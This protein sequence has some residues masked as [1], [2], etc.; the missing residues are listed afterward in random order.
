VRP[1]SR[2]CR[3]QT[4]TQTAAA[5]RQELRLRFLRQPS[6][7]LEDAESFRRGPEVEPR[8]GRSETR[9]TL[10]ARS[11][12]LAFR[13]LLIDAWPMGPIMNYCGAIPF[14][15]RATATSPFNKRATTISAPLIQ[16]GAAFVQRTNQFDA[17][18]P[19]TPLANE[20]MP[21]DIAISKDREFSNAQ[22]R[23][24]CWARSARQIRGFSDQKSRE[25]SPPRPKFNPDF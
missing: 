7:H 3:D 6:R 9:P 4:P 15:N 21:T 19:T 8:H 24:N 17:A 14:V 16:R 10:R 2:C 23:N 25:K 12:L 22:L 11:A 1:V 5:P 18:A 13:R 20:T